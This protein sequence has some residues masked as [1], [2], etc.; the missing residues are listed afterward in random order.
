MLG[1]AVRRPLGGGVW[2]TIQYAVG[3]QQLGHEVYYFEDSED[4]PCCYDPTRHVTDTDPTYGLGYA[5]AILDAVG[6]G[7]VWSYYDA[8]TGRWLGPCAD[9]AL[10]VCATADLV[11]TASGRLRPW[12]LAV[13]KRAFIDKDPLFFQV[14]HIQEPERRAA[15]AQHTSFFTYGACV[16]L[17]TSEVPDDGLPWQDHRQPVVLDLWPV[18]PP[19]AG[20]RYTTIMQ[21]DA[22]DPVRFD[23]RDYGMKSA[24][25]GPYEALPQRVG[26]LLEMGV[27]GSAVPKS[28]LREL[29]W[30]IVNPLEV[31]AQPAD[32]QKYIR[33][34]RGEFTVAKDGYVKSRT[35]W[36]SERSANYMASGRPVITQETGFSEWLPTGDGLFAFRTPDEA[37][38]AIEEVERRHEYH[39]RAARE[40][41]AVLAESDRQ[42]AA[43]WLETFVVRNRSFYRRLG[44]RT[45]GEFLEPVTG[46][47]YALMIRPPG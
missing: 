12:T 35:G 32:Y 26:P 8:H 43:T 10:E 38:A 13:P 22:Y 4:F 25:F 18:T 14:R 24:S 34:S 5:G 33:G 11:I 47:S 42:G 20:G 46:A 27:G 19:P 31:T 15:T 45:A 21:W 29:G 2:P 40:L 16:G 17:G 9:R 30:S 37:A 1:Y 7:E 3:L 6:L 41:C 36:F 23:G 44:Y 28:R 39:C